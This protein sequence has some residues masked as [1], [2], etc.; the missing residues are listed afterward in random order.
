MRLATAHSPRQKAI[1]LAA[2]TLLLLSLPSH[3][4]WKWRDK[5]GRV[6]VSDRPPPRDVAEKDILGRPAATSRAA[7][8]PA[9]AVSAMS[10]ASAVAEGKG[11]LDREVD[12]RRRAVEQDQAAKAKADEAR[13]ATQRAE[14]CQRAR[15]QINT[16]ESGQRLARVNSKGEREV[17]DDRARADEL[18]QARE[19]TA[20]NCR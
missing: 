1:F 12:A 19:A 14:N 2:F 3:A 5:D 17:L 13:V 20:A 11:P 7:L 10:A 16:L 18:A 6:T 8:S 9:S 4:Q 15:A